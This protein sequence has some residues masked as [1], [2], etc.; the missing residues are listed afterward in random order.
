MLHL[1]EGYFNKTLKNEG[2]GDLKGDSTILESIC[3]EVKGILLG[4][5]RR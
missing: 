5:A 1:F 2:S 4:G 3:L